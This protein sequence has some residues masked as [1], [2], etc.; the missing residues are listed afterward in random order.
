[1]DAGVELERLLARPSPLL[2]PWLARRVV[3]EDL[4]VVA[5]A[6]A[7]HLELVPGRRW[8]VVADATAAVLAQRMETGDVDLLH[9]VLRVLPPVAGHLASEVRRAVSWD[10]VPPAAAGYAALAGEREAAEWASADW[11]PLLAGNQARDPLPPLAHVGSLTLLREVRQGR[12]VASPAEAAYLLPH[13]DPVPP[14]WPELAVTAV[15]LPGCMAQPAWYARAVA[16]RVLPLLDGAGVEAVAAVFGARETDRLR[17][18]DRNAP[19]PEEELAVAHGGT[20][21][22][23]ATAVRVDLDLVAE[24]CRAATLAIRDV[25]DDLPA[26]RGVSYD[27]G[28]PGLP[29][30]APHPG[31]RPVRHVNVLVAPAG[32]SGYA[33]GPLPADTD[34][35]VLCSIG[36]LDP[37]SLTAAAVDATFPD[38]FLPDTALDLTALLTVDETVRT[39]ELHVPARRDSATVRLPLA[40]RPRGTV[41]EAELGLYYQVTLVHLIALVLPVE[42]AGGVPT[43]TVIHRLSTSLADL[44]PVADR[45]MSVSVSAPPGRARFLVNGTEF[46][47]RALLAEPSRVDTAARTVRTQLY[48]AHFRT[49]RGREVTRFDRRQGK[50]VADLTDDL[51]QLA[52]CGRKVYLE[53]FGAPSV[54]RTLPHFLRAESRDR[55][56]PPMIQI[57][58]PTTRATPVPWAAVYDLPLGSDPV[59][60]RPCPSIRDYGPGGRGQEAPV[61]CPYEDDH[62]KEN[63]QW[64]ANQLC[65]WGF[66]G[67]ST[68]LEHPPHAVERDLAAVVGAAPARVFLAADGPDLDDRGRRAHISALRATLGD[69]LDYVDQ[70]GADALAAALG[71]DVDVVYLFCHCGRDFPAAGA[72]P[73]PY[74]HFDRKIT[75]TDVNQW[76]ETTWPVDHWSNRRPLVIINGCHTV[77]TLSGSLSDFVVAFTSWAG[78]AGVI[79]TEV[80]VDQPVAAL[81]ME[82]FL[83][84]LR[85][86]PVGEALRSMRWA[87]IGRGNVMGLAYTPYCLANLVLRHRIGAA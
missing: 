57:I 49:V 50:S 40:G 82:L 70:P 19:R 8:P 27:Y 87:M 1:M 23:T 84:T 11:A 25:A 71:G 18:R 75:P 32:G 43:A 46:E 69:E 21:R 34:L 6:A 13:L 59:A 63:G 66:W 30:V 58:D 37:R 80:T 2:L 35:E 39:A 42:G 72:P 78:G 38:E 77:E 22:L 5:S 15:D 24:L 60:Y 53:M 55:Q 65:P 33:R 81:A 36:A 73:D 7:L 3:A 52:H 9:R 47:A 74:L 56:R 20:A 51:R 16:A 67:L 17:A 68:L 14:G 4:R 48:D 62:R 12:P 79:G 29:A 45:S 26:E 31:G 85:T 86:R 54:A 44:A 28:L 61:R 64:R 76:I 83:D 41:I 10:A